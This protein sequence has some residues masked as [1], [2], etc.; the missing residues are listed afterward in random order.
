MIRTV[1]SERSSSALPIALRRISSSITVLQLQFS[2][3]MTL[4]GTRREPFNAEIEDV[5]GTRKQLCR[6]TDKF[7]GKIG[8]KKK[9]QFERR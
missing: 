6:T 2:R 8:V 7:R 5:S 3:R 1:R 4:G 9:F